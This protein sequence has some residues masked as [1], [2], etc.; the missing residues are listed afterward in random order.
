MTGAVLAA[1]AHAGASRTAMKVI[2]TAIACLSFRRDRCISLGLRSCVPVGSSLSDC[3]SRW[4]ERARRDRRSTTR[5]GT[6]RVRC[7]GAGS[8]VSLGTRPEGRNCRQPRYPGRSPRGPEV[9]RPRLSTGVPLSAIGLAPSMRTSKLS[10]RRGN[11]GAELSTC[12]KFGAALQRE[13]NYREMCDCSN[14]DY[15]AIWG[16]LDLN[17]CRHTVGKR[18]MKSLQRSRTRKI[19]R[20]D[21]EPRWVVDTTRRV[22]PSEIDTDMNSRRERSADSPAHMQPRPPLSRPGF[23]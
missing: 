19:S 1:S 4:H 10:D 16:R 12:G 5:S 3:R 11:R 9:L 17:I 6:R 14:L 13:G 2:T 7:W 20:R 23:C 22:L 8:G 18:A 15:V 21:S